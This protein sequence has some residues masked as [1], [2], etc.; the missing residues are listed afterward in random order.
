MCLAGE[1][2]SC[3]AEYQT[4]C[5]KFHDDGVLL[6][7]QLQESSRLNLAV[8]GVKVDQGSDTVSQSPDPACRRQLGIW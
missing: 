5:K 7:R 8:S 2:T 4:W 6:P 1:D 3:V